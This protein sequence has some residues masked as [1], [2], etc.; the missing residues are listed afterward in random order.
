MSES[1]A[2]GASA[3]VAIMSSWGGYIGPAWLPL[4]VL[5][6]E[7]EV[8]LRVR[9]FSTKLRNAVGRKPHNNGS[10]A[11]AACLCPAA[12]ARRGSSLPQC[13]PGRSWIK[14][15]LFCLPP[16][17]MEHTAGCLSGFKSKF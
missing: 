17:G 14:I 8:D 13:A 12:L 6:F 5:N 10:S 15:L 9:Q 16:E 2:L 11:R 7:V 3:K 4:V 1:T